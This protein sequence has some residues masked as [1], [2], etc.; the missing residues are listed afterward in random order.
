MRRQQAIAL[1]PDQSGVVLRKTIRAP[2]TCVLRSSQ[3]VWIS[4]RSW[5]SAANSAA[6]VVSGSR[7]GVT[8]RESG[9]ASGPPLQPVLDHADHDAVVAVPPILRRRGHPAQLG[10]IGQPG[11]GRKAQIRFDPPEQRR[12]GT[13]PDL[14]VTV[15]PASGPRSHWTPSSSQRST[16][17]EDGCL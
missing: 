2:R 13:I 8:R 17:R 4:Q 3:A 1:L 7:I 6:G 16:A 5:S 14:P 9:S 12:A 10:P 11:G 15:T